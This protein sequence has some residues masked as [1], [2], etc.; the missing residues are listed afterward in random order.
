MKKLLDRLLFRLGYI[1]I[2]SPLIIEKREYEIQL[3]KGIR[4]V[5]YKSL[6]KAQNATE[7]MNLEIAGLKREMLE[8]AE[9][10]IDLKVM[11]NHD[12][13]CKEINARLFVASKKQ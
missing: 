1:P 11:D 3:L 6:A 12:L 5:H 13:D 4:L 10:W 9:L 7:L 2:R 8:K